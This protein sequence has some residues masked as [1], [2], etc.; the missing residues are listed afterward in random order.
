MLSR[1]MW[2]TIRY[3]TLHFRDRREAALLRHINRGR[4]GEQTKNDSSFSRSAI[5]TQYI[6]AWNSLYL[7]ALHCLS[8]LQVDIVLTCMVRYFANKKQKQ[9]GK[10]RIDLFAQSN[11]CSSYYYRLFELKW[12]EINQE[13]ITRRNEQNLYHGVFTNSFSVARICPTTQSA[14]PTGRLR[15]IFWPFKDVQFSFLVSYSSNALA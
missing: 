8:N 9:N 14:K 13:S 6:V 3:V 5:S 7:I 1:I 15:M 12:N 2:A 10:Q 11:G 4:G